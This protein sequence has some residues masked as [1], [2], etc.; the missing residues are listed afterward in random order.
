MR[1]GL[2]RASMNPVFSRAVHG[3]RA[4]FGGALEWDGAA[5]LDPSAMA[6]TALGMGVPILIGVLAGHPRVGLAASLGAMWVG[7]APRGANLSEHW[8]TVR[9]IVLAAIGAASAAALIARHGWW[10]DIGLVLTAGIAALLG[11]FSRPAAIASQRF[12]VFVTIGLGVAT[13][14]ADRILL[15]IMIAEGAI[16]AALCGL[17]VGAAA[18]RWGIGQIAPAE[19][20]SSVS[21][22]RLYRRWRGLLATI[23][24]WIYSLRLMACLGCAVVIREAMPQHHYSW[25]AVA[26]A[27][28]TQRQGDGLVVK[29]MQRA[30]GVA[31]GVV[32][33]EAIA[34]RPLPGWTLII[35]IAALAAASPWLRKRSYVAYTAT[36][37]PLI[38]LLTSGGGSI[39]QGLLIDRLVATLIAA[40]LVI[41][42][43]LAARR[44]M[45]P[46]S[47]DSPRSN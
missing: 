18:R 37:T 30:M 34:S 46:P 12:I 38:L 32:A 25:I 40:G 23:G 10:S 24:G 6:G 7:N 11:G 29:V 16:W 8:R 14:A 31:A 35:V 2:S 39:A 17:A 22:V 1:A 13:Q 47:P 15:T 3:T 4:V 43:F 9:D 36:T 33:T 42:A 41:A 28:L 20:R 5:A 21:F 45:L 27:L 26:V 19:P 44:F